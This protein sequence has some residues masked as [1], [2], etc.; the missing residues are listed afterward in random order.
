MITYHLAS[1]T[2]K[3]LSPVI[4]VFPG[5]LLVD[6]IDIFLHRLHLLPTPWHLSPPIS[7][8]PVTDF[9]VKL[10]PVLFQ[11]LLGA[12]LGGQAFGAAVRVRTVFQTVVTNLGLGDELVILCV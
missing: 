4:A 1:L 6:S 9:L 2:I 8:P 12:I 11:T 10:D 7:S 5:T 3:N